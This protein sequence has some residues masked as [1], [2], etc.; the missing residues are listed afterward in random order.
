MVVRKSQTN[1]RMNGRGSVLTRTTIGLSSVFIIGILPPLARDVPIAASI[2]AYRRGGC[3]GKN[4]D[5]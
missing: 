2:I 4:K 5:C 1:A 3:Q